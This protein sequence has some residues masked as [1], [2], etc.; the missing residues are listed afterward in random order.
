MRKCQEWESIYRMFTYTYKYEWALHLLHF[1]YDV[2]S[3]RYLDG[4][5]VKI[6][7]GYSGRSKNPKKFGFNIQTPAVALQI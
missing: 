2:V 5:P 3:V 4:K 1:L 7:I 6:H